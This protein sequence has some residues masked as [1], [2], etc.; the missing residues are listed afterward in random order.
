MSR[1]VKSTRKTHIDEVRLGE[2]VNETGLFVEV[3][4]ELGMRGSRKIAAWWYGVTCAGNCSAMKYRIMQA[5]YRWAILTAPNSHKPSW[6]RRPKRNHAHPAKSLNYQKAKIEN[7][8][9][10]EIHVDVIVSKEARKS[11]REYNDERMKHMRA[12]SINIIN[13]FEIGLGK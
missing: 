10:C 9:V 12:V 6:Q 8:Y 3:R 7:I 11:Q 1:L 5:A 4:V 13:L 2:W